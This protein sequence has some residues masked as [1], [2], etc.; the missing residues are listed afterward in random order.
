MRRFG[1][2]LFA[3]CMTAYLVSAQ[4]V[5]SEIPRTAQLAGKVSGGAPELQAWKDA[6]DF[7]KA[8]QIL[9]PAEFGELEMGY[10]RFAFTVAQVES[11]RLIRETRDLLV[12]NVRAG[13][14]LKDWRKAVDQAFAKAG[15]D[16]MSPW[17]AETVYRTNI[18]SAYSAGNYDML[19]HPAVAEEFPVFRFEG[20]GD[21]RQS[22]ICRPIDGVTLPRDNAFWRYHWPPLHHA[23]RSTVRGIHQSRLDEIE[24]TPAN[25][26]PPVQ[27]DEG[28]GYAGGKEKHWEVAKP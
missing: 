17:H 14:N 5:W 1:E 3:A 18:A 2:I 21:D 4:E 25:R 8:K 28:F 13:G 6:A 19:H 23:C 20:V 26:I 24:M 7:L 27:P 9:T 10:R 15:A 16:P 11:K 12:E 22:D